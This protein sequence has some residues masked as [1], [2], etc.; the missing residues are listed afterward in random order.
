MK[1][2]GNLWQQ[3]ISVD[4]LWL[5]YKKAKK[6]KANRDS[7]AAFSFNV[8]VEL[9][10]LQEALLTGMYQPGKYRQFIIKERKQRLISAAPFRDR[11]VHHAIMNVLEPILDK[12]F[13]YHS[14]ACRK[15]KGVHKAVVQ[16]QQWAEKYPYVLKLDIAR[17]FPSINHK[18]LKNQLQSIIKDKSL[19]NLLDLIIDASPTPE[20]FIGLPI[21]NLTSQYF[22]NLYLNEIDHWLCTL[23]QVKGYLRYVDDLMILGESKVELWQLKNIL[24]QQLQKLG[25]QL[26]IKKQQLMRTTERVDILGYVVSKDKRWLRNDNGHRFQRKLKH[27]AT[28]YKQGKLEM[29]EIKPSVASWIGHAKHGETLALRKKIFTAC[30]F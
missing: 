30:V 25:L 17:Y 15:G 6:G 20:D 23:P 7:V 5:A 29:A 22:A 1:R 12:R 24:E 2:I 28:L 14:Y 3:V 26:H 18:T 19:L 4:N 21:G 13:Y 10:A 8:E 27:K 11:V 16:Y 9:H